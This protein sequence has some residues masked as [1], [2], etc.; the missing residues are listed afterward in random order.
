MSNATAVQA[1]SPA[2]T[3]AQAAQ[4][5]NNFTLTWRPAMTD[6]A[7]QQTKVDFTFDVSER[8]PFLSNLQAGYQ[9]R[10]RTGNGWAGGG[11]TVRP[12]T[13]ETWARRDMWRRSWFRPKT[14]PSIIAP[15]CRRRPPP[16][17]A[18]TAMSGD[19]GRHQQQPRRQS[20][21]HA[22][23]HDDVHAHRTRALI[24]SALYTKDYPFLGDYPDKGNVMTNWPYINPAA[25]AAAM[26]PQAFDLHCMKK[27]TANDGNVYQQPHSAYNEVT[28]AGY[29]MFDFEQ[30][31]PLDMIFNGNI[32]TRYVITDDERN[33]L[34]DTGP[35]GSDSGLRPGHQSRRHS[36]HDGRAQ[37]VTQERHR[38]L[39]AGRTTSISGSCPTSWCSA[40]TKAR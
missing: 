38:G 7:E 36:H 6:D 24:S 25:I 23:R 2:Y 35:H 19:H 11:Y 22:V 3:A 37:Y 1:G 13:G 30:K 32:G 12:G 4:W 40:T 18:S 20:E 10:D 21:Q 29:F 17:P 15:A 39:A 5:G 14:S 26:P 9:R 31:M 8:L 28:D 16:S 33:G 27:C 34:H